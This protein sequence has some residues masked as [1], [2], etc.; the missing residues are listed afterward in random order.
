V[1]GVG[2]TSAV[3]DVVNVKGGN[4]LKLFEAVFV[5]SVAYTYTG[6]PE[7]MV[8]ASNKPVT[9]VCVIVVPDVPIVYQVTVSGGVRPVIFTPNTP[10]L[11]HGAVMMEKETD[12]DRLTEANAIKRT[13]RANFL[14]IVAFVIIRGVYVCMTLF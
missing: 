1:P 9:P 7:Y 13:K 10:S 3:E 6:P 2:H 4:P 12:W 14:I 8:S 5:P 11:L